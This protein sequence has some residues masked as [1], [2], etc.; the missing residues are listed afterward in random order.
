V[1]QASELAELDDL[2]R[3]RVLD[4]E[5]VQRIIE[6]E[7]LPRFEGRRSSPD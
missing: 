2:G 6:G 4:R 5:P 7:E 1:P 3:E